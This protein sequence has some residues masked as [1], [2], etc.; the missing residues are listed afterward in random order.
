MDITANPRLDAPPARSMSPLKEQRRHF[1]RLV[2]VLWFQRRGWLMYLAVPVTL[3]LLAPL[4][5][6]LW[7]D[8]DQVLYVTA[9]FGPAF[10]ATMILY[11]ACGA[12]A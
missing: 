6:S 2:W 4:V 10:L 5:A 9:C 11:T 12:A 8:R 1:R 3:I 7:L